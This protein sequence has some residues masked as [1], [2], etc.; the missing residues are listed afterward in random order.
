EQTDGDTAPGRLLEM[1][2]PGRLRRILYPEPAH[3]IGLQL[4]DFLIH[5][6]ARRLDLVRREQRVERPGLR[7]DLQPLV[8]L[9]LHVRAHL[10]AQLLDAAFLDAERFRELL[11]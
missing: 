2:G 10:D 11:V 8:E 7:L 3:R 4:P 5:E 6:R 9:A 1:L